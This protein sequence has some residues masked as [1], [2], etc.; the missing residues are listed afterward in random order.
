MILIID[1]GRAQA[2]SGHP[3]S[4]DFILRGLGSFIRPAA[5]QAPSPG[6]KAA[7]SGQSALPRI[8]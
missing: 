1:F 8:S 5:T 4:A 2:L 7:M 3:V 6:L